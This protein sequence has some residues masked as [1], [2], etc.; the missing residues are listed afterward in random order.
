MISSFALALALLSPA[1][2]A[3]VADDHLADIVARQTVQA[4][5]EAVLAAVSDL[6]LQESLLV[7]CTRRWEHGAMNS[8]PGASATLVYKVGVWRRKL[9]ATISEVSP[10]RR[11]VVDHAGDKGFI[12][13][14]TALQG[15]EGTE[16]ELR[17][18][19]NLPPR[20]FR[21]IFVNRVQVGWQA[22]YA[23]ALV[24]LDA[25]LR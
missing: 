22:C 2:A 9:A 14:W 5:P 1:S 19:L 17:T 8:G 7:D 11:V 20:P 18:L 12:T 24:R 25:A 21:K 16:V 23:D 4:S 3:P 6:H 13:V 10:G 15:N